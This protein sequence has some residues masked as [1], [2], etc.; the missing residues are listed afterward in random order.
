[1]NK[2]SK[3]DRLRLE[4]LRDLMLSF[5]HE[6]EKFSSI[7]YKLKSLYSMLETIK[8]DQKQTIFEFWGE[9]EQI[10]AAMLASNRI[11]LTREENKEVKEIAKQAKE[12]C[13][14]LLEIYHPE[15]DDPYSW[16]FEEYK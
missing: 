4:L 3:E 8:D 16:P 1:M 7:P 10:Y 2:I 14:L 12:Y 6:R 15:P 9:F 13:D 5:L 11:E